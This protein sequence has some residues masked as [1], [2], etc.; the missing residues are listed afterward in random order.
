MKWFGLAFSI[1]AGVAVLSLLRARRFV[2]SEGRFDGFTF[3]S[4]DEQAVTVRATLEEAEAAWV[5]WCASGHA[6]L[7]DNYAVRFEP[8]PGARG[9]E[10]HL[11]GGGSK[12][13]IREELR[14]FKQLVET[15]E[16]PVGGPAWGVRLSRQRN[17]ALRC[18]DASQLLARNAEPPG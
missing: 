6:K 16:L 13:R 15:G 1:A 4:N 11:S 2:T 3:D 5:A 10:V 17:R 12:S 9:T 7:K 8:A 18:R 14:G